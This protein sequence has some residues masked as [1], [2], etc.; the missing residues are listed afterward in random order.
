VLSGSTSEAFSQTVT[1]PPLPN[2]DGTQVYFSQPFEL[3]GRRNI[4]I[5][6]DSA[7]QNSWVYLEGDLINDETGVVQSFPIDIS[8][9]QGVE[10]GE[11]WSEGGQK[12]SAYTSALPAGRY[13]LR[14]EGQWERWQQPA[15]VS[16]RVEQNVT[17]GFN[18]ILAL[19][20]LSL[21]P[22][23]MGIYHIS[24]ERRRWSESMFDESG[25]SDDDDDDE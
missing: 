10:D 22:I 13:I 5:A 4:R 24:F 9:Y 21:V 25:S 8:Y 12:D 11:S 15:T 16:I 14:L 3:K 6:G 2:A 17:H 20:V 23:G 7:V 19:I 18:L 1:L